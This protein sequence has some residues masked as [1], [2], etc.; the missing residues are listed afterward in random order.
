MLARAATTPNTSERF[1]IESVSILVGG[2][3]D[4]AAEEVI[5]SVH[6]DVVVAGGI[7]RQLTCLWRVVEPV[8]EDGATPSEEGPSVCSRDR[9]VDKDV[10]LG[11]ARDVLH[12]LATGRVVDIPR[13]CDRSP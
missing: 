6:L 11:E 8:R 13:Y 9:R 5:V 3:K 1:L 12:H 2:H 7:V 10:G 4:S